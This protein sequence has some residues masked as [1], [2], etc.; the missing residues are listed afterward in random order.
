M[1]WWQI[2]R[3]TICYLFILILNIIMNNNLVLLIMINTSVYIHICG[4]Y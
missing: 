1:K 2:A 3:F 4:K